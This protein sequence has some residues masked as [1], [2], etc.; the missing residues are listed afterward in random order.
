MQLG[1]DDAQRRIVLQQRLVNF[2]QPFEDGRVKDSVSRGRPR[3]R[4]C[5]KLQLGFIAKQIAVRA[6][7]F[8]TVA[9]MIAPR[10]VK[11]KGD[12]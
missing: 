6:R 7:A 12:K 2:R 9:A 10:S 5:L 1:P 4:G 3:K 11:A 8:N